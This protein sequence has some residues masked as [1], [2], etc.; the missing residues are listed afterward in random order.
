MD[1]EGGILR[2]FEVWRKKGAGRAGE[3]EG[4]YIILSS[5][6]LG[7]RSLHLSW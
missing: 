2:G 7:R 4:N 1:V 5:G 3:I 6:Q